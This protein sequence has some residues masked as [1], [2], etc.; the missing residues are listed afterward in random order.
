LEEW[1]NTTRKGQ[2][3]CIL[4]NHLPGAPLIYD[5]LSP[6]KYEGVKAYRQS[7]DKWQPD[8]QDEGQF[9]LQDLSVT[10]GKDVTFAHCFIKCGGILPDGKTFEDMIRATFCLLEANPPLRPP[11]WLRPCRGAE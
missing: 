10:A 6:M 5:V 11:L 7:S 1:A 9:E 3:D 2:Q 8:T 4:S